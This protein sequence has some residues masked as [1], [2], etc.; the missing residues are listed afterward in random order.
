MSGVFGLQRFSWYQ[1][2]QTSFNTT[3]AAWSLNPRK[4]IDSLFI[5]FLKIM[6]GIIDKEIRGEVLSHAFKEHRFNAHLLYV[7]SYSFRKYHIPDYLMTFP[8]PV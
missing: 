5:L 2:T 1:N 8:F 6:K 4:S 3:E 7:N